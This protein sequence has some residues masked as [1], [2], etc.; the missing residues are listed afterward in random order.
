MT[1]SE[2]HDIVLEGCA[3]VP[4]AGYLKALGVFRII[5]EQA[6]TEARGFWRNERFVLRTRFPRREFMLFLLKQ[7]RPTPVVSPWNGGSGFYFQEGK[8]K[9]KDPVT[10]K[11][12]KTGIRNQPTT[13]TRTL[14]TLQ[15]STSARFDTGAARKVVGI[16]CAISSKR[17]T[18]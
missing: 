8:T 4:L 2:R 17:E 9:E 7:Y 15:D 18:I 5:G 10:G 1:T 3:P 16:R 12:V 11:R 13:A 6:D 14:D